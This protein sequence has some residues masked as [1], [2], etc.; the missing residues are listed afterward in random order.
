M[1]K[2]RITAAG[3]KVRKEPKFT[4][5]VL[6]TLDPPTTVEGTLTMNGYIETRIPPISSENVF[7]LLDG[8]A[9]AV[10][11]KPLP[12]GPE[13]ADALCSLVTAEARD[14]STDRDYLLAVAY[15]LTSS[16]AKPVS[17]DGTKVGPFQYSEAAWAAATTD[18]PAKGLGCT[19]DHRLRWYEQ[20]RVAALVTAADVKEFRKAFDRLPQ[21]KELYFFQL[22]GAQ[23]LAALR[24]PG[25]ACKSA[26]PEPAAD[27][28]YAKE[29]QAGALTVSEALDGL[30]ER[31]DKA[32]VKALE[33]I[34]KQPADI[35]F[36][37][38]QPGDAPWMAVARDEMARGVSEDSNKRNTAEITAYFAE[39]GF[40]DDG[41]QPWC[42]AFV[43]HCMKQCGVA[44]VAAT[45]NSPNA[46][47]TPFWEKWGDPAP[48]PNPIGTVIVLKPGGAGGHVGF[49]AEGS[50]AATI[51]LL[52]G[53]QGGGGGA[54]PDHVGIVDFPIATNPV[55]AR[56]WKAV[57]APALSFDGVEAQAG[58]ELFVEKAPVVM[59]QLKDAFPEMED[60]H[61]AAI[62]GNIGQECGGFRQLRQRDGQGR[63]LPDSA[64]GGF[65]W[66]QWD[67][68]GPAF[69]AFAKAAGLD[70]KDD[71]ANLGYLIHE[72]REKTKENAALLSLLQQK[73][74]DQ[75][76][77]D[78]DRKFER[79]G[80]PMIKNRIRYAR[81]ALKCFSE[82]P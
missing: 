31:L 32:Y 14:A 25:K 72:L 70:W 40:K 7:I 23:A 79:S 46:V 55:V 66:C 38:S 74:L 54:R 13:D 12:F 65:G 37:R 35:R 71:K 11:T 45:V 64:G 59:Q 4:A 6:G 73:S 3:S 27:G 41:T 16:L 81:L 10:P 57:A 43:A 26:L 24:E 61:A 8:S 15:D 42:A 2:F 18:G 58:D 34:E 60:I 9:E 78:F 63:E 69:K 36:F 77:I 39:V 20:P 49:L 19:A 52:G 76:V 17:D 53:N 68:R 1:A 28:S 48:D 29:L 30:Q 62:L 56:R 5:Q 51:R 47:G 33:V 22:I 50:S 80:R 67:D 82:R 44:D 75:A 21:F